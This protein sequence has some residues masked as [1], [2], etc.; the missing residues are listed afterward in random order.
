[1]AIQFNDTTNKLGLIQE[2]ESGLFGDDY[3]AISG[4]T[5]KLK[6]FTRLLNL[7]LSRYSALVRNADT[8]WSFHDSNYTTHPIGKTTLVAG[9]K[10]YT[11]AEIH[12]QI[13]QVYVK[14]VNGKDVPLI[15]IDEYDIAKQ[16][17]APTQFMSED[18][19]PK[20]YDK[21]GRSLILYPAPAVGSFT[22]SEGL[23]VS[24]V[25]SPS[26]FEST[27]TDKT[28]GIEPVFQDYPAIFA[29][30][31][32]AMNNQM[33]KKANSFTEQLGDME[34]L[35]VEHYSKR[36]RDDKQGMRAKKRSYK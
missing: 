29:K 28:A 10:D 16:N 35:I 13:R 4:N 1:M 12:E 17:V 9:Q 36:D 24:Y 30:R 33:Q 5:K 6:T 14:D 25:S 32:Y 27:D 34:V 21:M 8:R 18:G 19:M 15:P 20:Y 7:G 3:G 31:H 23:V 22:A 2:C 11:L 26:F